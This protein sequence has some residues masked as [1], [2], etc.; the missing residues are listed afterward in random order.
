MYPN[1]IKLVKIAKENNIKNK[2]ITNGVEL[3]KNEEAKEIY[4]YLD[5][6]TLSI[7]S[8][9]SDT[10]NNLGRGINHYNN[11]KQILDY[12]KDKNI[13]L[14]IN[15]VINKE[16]INEVQDLG[17]FLN[18]YKIGL[19]KL[20]KFMPLRETAEKNKNF[21]E[22]SDKEFEN[23]ENSVVFKK[24]ENISSFDC[25]KEEDMEKDILIIANGDIYKTENGKDY[26]KG[27]ALYDNVVKF[28]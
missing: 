3:V 25:R 8:V 26:K 15:T 27:N 17:E 10:N 4:N 14:D 5:S 22:I 12:V 6:L 13:E 1:L 23:F 16:N 9:N 18:H 21:F 24:F 11:V 19:W 7:D 20:Y 2:L 28:I